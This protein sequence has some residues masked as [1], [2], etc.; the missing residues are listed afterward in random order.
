MSFKRKLQAQKRKAE[1]KASSVFFIILG[2]VGTWLVASSG[3][4][5]LDTYIPLSDGIKLAVGCGA[6]YLGVIEFKK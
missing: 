6:I 2:I 5:L 3:N 1:R 4:N